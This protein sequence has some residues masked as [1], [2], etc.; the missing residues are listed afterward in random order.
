MDRIVG[1][2]QRWARRIEGRASMLVPHGRWLE[3]VALLIVIAI[4][5]S[6]RLD[7]LGR[8]REQEART[9]VHG[10]P[11]PVGLDAFVYLSLAQDL[12]ENVDQEM[13]EKR[14][15]PDFAPRRFPPPLLSVL[16]AGISRVTPFSLS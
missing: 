11:I 5:V 6:F 15:V 9:F 1:G 7:D 3:L 4:G 16:A 14:G 8:W 10:E 13:N 2:L 12:L